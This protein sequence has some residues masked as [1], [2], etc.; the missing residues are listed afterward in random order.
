MRIVVVGAGGVG[1]YFGG[2]L[3]RAG[4]AVTLVAR[5]A[6]LEAIRREGLRVRSA[7]EGEWVA[8]P[9]AVAEVNGLPPADAVLLCV[10]AFD[11]EPALTG[12]RPVVGPET[13][14]LTLQNGIDNVEKID[15]LLG[16]GHA[17]G[18]AAYVFAT[19]D[20][21]GV[22]AHRFAGRI[23][24]GELD[25]VPR[26]RTERLRDAFARARVP[27]ELST[28]IHRVM[29]EKYLFICAQAGMTALAR[30]PSGV[31]RQHPATWRMYR[32][33]VEELAAVGRA[34]GV[35]LPGD[36]VDTIMAA[37]ASL[38][39][40]TFSSLH[41]D[42]VEGRR[43]ELEALHGHAARLGERLGVPTPTVAA[44]YAALRPHADGRPR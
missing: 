32:T 21:P 14:V 20:G 9:E 30:A 40:D 41:H 4:E 29:W 34:A 39:A 33:I 11:T 36:V 43:L 15:A 10:K 37:A 8:R 22:V 6:H 31:L 7:I 25:G 17:L 12:V 19:L 13:A 27:V 3:A 26:A 42:L 23:A 2:R 44:V 5:G 16:A 24:L 35:D 18:G 1:G 28:A 38:G